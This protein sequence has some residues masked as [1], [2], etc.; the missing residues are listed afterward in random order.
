MI[1]PED[2]KLLH[3][4]DNEI[5]LPKGGLNLESAFVFEAWARHNQSS[6]SLPLNLT[7]PF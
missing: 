4:S 2:F 7:P 3:F 5:G 1:T 6:S